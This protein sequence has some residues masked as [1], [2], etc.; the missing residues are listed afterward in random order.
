MENDRIET[1]YGRLNK[2][3]NG[4]GSKLWIIRMV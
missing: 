1:D 2:I 3:I 4:R